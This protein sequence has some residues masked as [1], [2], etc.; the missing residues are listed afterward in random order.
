MEARM[1][2]RVS[3]LPLEAAMEHVPPSFVSP[4]VNLTV[5]VPVRVLPSPPA[6]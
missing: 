4:P 5:M 6:S 3:P 1:K 2:S